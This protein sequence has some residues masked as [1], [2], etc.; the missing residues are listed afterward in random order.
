[1]P[2]WLRADWP[3]PDSI[4]AGTTLR[5]LV[6]FDF[7]AEPCWLNQVHG[8]RVVRVGSD[9]FAAGPP[10]ADA[11]IAADP[12]SICVVRTAD[13]L[14]ILF[15]SRDGTQIAAAHA[16]WRGLAGGV[17]EATISALGGSPDDLIAWFGP[18]I[19][20]AAFEVGSEVR[21]AFVSQ[22]AGAAAAFEPN[23][24]GRW[25]ADLYE[26]ARRRLRAAGVQAIYG[27]GLCTFGDA[28]R[29]YSYRRDGTTGRLVSF[30]YRAAAKP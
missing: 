1:M 23:A 11:S 29:F 15:C 28:A 10:E 25:Q 26:L 22:D 17:A 30:V 8:N 20:Q 16:G 6:D 14:P 2:D 27:G 9:D 12:E 24:R 21:A 7:P 19:S 18:A 4:V 13:C 5:P 3:A